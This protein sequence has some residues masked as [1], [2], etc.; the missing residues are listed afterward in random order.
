MRSPYRIGTT[1]FVHPAGWLENVRRLAGRVEDVEI[2][3][4]DAP[5]PASAPGPDEIAALA[6]LGREAGLTWSVHAPLDVALASED[7]ARRRAGIDEPL[8]VLAEIEREALA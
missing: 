3:L 8:A 2:P 7:P 5:T 1:S 4:L 6:R